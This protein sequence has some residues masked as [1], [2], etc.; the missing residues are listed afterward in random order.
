[1]RSRHKIIPTNIKGFGEFGSEAVALFHRIL[2]R[3]KSFYSAF[4]FPTILR[5]RMGLCCIDVRLVSGMAA[6]SPRLP[7]ALKWKS[8]S[9]H[10]WC[11]HCLWP[12]HFNHVQSFFLVC[13]LVWRWIDCKV[14][15][16]HQM[17]N[18]NASCYK[19]KPIPLVVLNT[20]SVTENISCTPDCDL[21]GDLH[22]FIKSRQRCDPLC[23][24][25]NTSLSAE[26]D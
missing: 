10:V 5:R 25:I 26:R 22:P 9:G 7:P 6:V 1:M 21:A 11:D 18:G 19:W 15:N 23:W 3:K 8:I 14:L 16:F 24:I 4:N 17:W 12:P 20:E 2:C 13:S